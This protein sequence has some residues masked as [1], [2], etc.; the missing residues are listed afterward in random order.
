MD[1]FKKLTQALG[2][3]GRLTLMIVALVLTSV[4]LVSSLVYVQYRDSFTQATLENMQGTGEMTSGSF[5]SWLNARQDEVS[6]LASLNA[7]TQVDIE[8]LNHLL[9]QLANSKG[10]YDTIFFVSPEG[11]GLAGV[12]YDGSAQ[13]LSG[14]EA[15][16][17]NVADRAWF[18]EA[19]VGKIV[20]SAP[21]VSR[22][23]GNQ[24]SN[25]VVPVYNNGRV[26]G[27][28]RAAVALDTLF[29]IIHELDLA[30]QSDTYLL[31]SKGDP[32]T[33]VA[34]L[35]G[36][37]RTLTT[38]PAQAFATGTSGVGRYP[39]P[40]GRDVI[41][42]YTFVPMLGWGVVL[43]VDAAEALNEVNR[44]FWTLTLI[45][46]AI[47]II[48]ILLSLAVVRSVVRTLGGDPTFAASIV[49]RVA[50]GDLT[51]NV[52]LKTGDTSSLLSSISFMQ[53]NLQTMM[54]DVSRYSDE[55]AAAATELS[56]I[57]RETEQG[58]DAQTE[59]VNS[60]V[61]AINEMT[62]TVEEVARNTQFAAESA[63]TTTEE[64][65]SGRQVVDEAIHAIQS[66]AEEVRNSAEVINSLKMDSDSI[67]SVLQV[68]RDVAEQT[69]LL[70]L[71]A[72]IEAARAGEEGR[73]FAVVADEVR[74]LASR[75]QASAAQIQQTV[76]KL[77]NQA[78]K[79]AQVMKVSCERASSGVEHVTVAGESL[80][81]IA[82]SVSRID[83]MTQQIATAT[84]EQTAVAQEIN[85]N[86]H[87]VS[88]ISEQNARNV[89][90]SK[91]AGEALAHLAE[92]LR[93]LVG[94]F[95]V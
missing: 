90:Q 42:S 25:V 39:D 15:Y 49:K 93:A 64:A 83:D 32:V 92:E 19:I 27:V 24:I 11:R 37:N 59:Q 88:S 47:L 79:A 95:R 63:R 28:V 67:G 60:V 80:N 84:E 56:Q 4:T 51:V 7:A 6:Y 89:D 75:T 21:L 94:Q 31:D 57:N 66:L 18:R 81:K 30:G 22:A 23:T 41:G 36:V 35:N 65:T 86:V 53:H 82:E 38:E 12:S 48:A 50:D 69:N 78:D 61:V 20:F 46:G 40:A 17:F 68:I 1:M 55:V 26:V 14:D 2:F 9:A 33:A 43:E 71:N 16:A 13:I 76:Q 74:T 73:G 44:M 29:E 85:A 3:G 70:A 91:Q 52:P 58:I 77:Q 62:A 5:V 8:Q 45:T 54:T 10:Y 34:A 87:G 72:A